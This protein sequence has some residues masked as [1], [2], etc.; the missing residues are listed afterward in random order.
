MTALGMML[1]PSPPG[2]ARR[3]NK[4]PLAPTQHTEYRGQATSPPIWDPPPAPLLKI[5]HADTSIMYVGTLSIL[6]G[7]LALQTLRTH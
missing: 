1:T 7:R 6:Q 2:G 5:A 4:I 3:G